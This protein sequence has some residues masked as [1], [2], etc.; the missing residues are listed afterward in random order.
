F[1][2]GAEKGRFD[3]VLV[4]SGQIITKVDIT[5]QLRTI[6]TGPVAVAPGTHDDAV[7][8]FRVFPFNGLISIQRSIKI[9][10]IKPAADHQY[11]MVDI[12]QM[13]QDV[14]ALPDFILA[15]LR[16]QVYLGEGI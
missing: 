10:R 1:E 3:I 2:V 12:T 15:T 7:F 5:D 16:C 6:G 11:G 14:S 8:R 9:F 4:E 13:W